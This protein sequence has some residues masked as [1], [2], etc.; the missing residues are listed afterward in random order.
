MYTN[1]D[2]QNRTSLNLE[3]ILPISLSKYNCESLDIEC[4]FDTPTDIDFPHLGSEYRHETPNGY[5]ITSI[6]RLDLPRKH[7][8]QRL[9]ILLEIHRVKNKTIHHIFHSHIVELDSKRKTGNMKGVSKAILVSL[10][11]Y[12]IK[13]KFSIKANFIFPNRYTTGI[14][15]PRKM[16]FPINTAEYFELIGIRLGI[17][18]TAEQKK[19]KYIHS[20]NFRER[21]K[22]LHTISIDYE[23]TLSTSLFNDAVQMCNHLAK[24]ILFEKHSQS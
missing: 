20:M 7:A 2:R 23:S 8:Q 15:L 24:K 6:E 17:K 18:E 13:S 10:E 11:Q 9:F 1:I 5:F 3:S 19:H 16:G 14:K 4:T 12:G 22:I 21:N